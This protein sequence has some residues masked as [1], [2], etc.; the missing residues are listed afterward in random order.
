LRHTCCLFALRAHAATSGV[1]CIVRPV[2]VNARRS[3]YEWSAPTCSRT[4]V[5]P[6]KLYWAKPPLVFQAETYASVFAKPLR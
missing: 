4:M 2:A 6:L 3:G 1:S 5:C